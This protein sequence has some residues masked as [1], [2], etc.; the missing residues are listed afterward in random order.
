M[1]LRS[2]HIAVAVTCC[3]VVAIA[4]GL[5]LRASEPPD[6]AWLAR[7]PE[8]LIEARI[9]LPQADRHRPLAA[10]TM[11]GGGAAPG[12]LPL[13]TLARLEK[14]G[15]PRELAEA[16]L[17][18][19][20]PNL[21][22]EALRQLEGVQPSPEVE[23]DRS[24]ALL[25]K[26][27]LEEA[28]RSVD[29]ALERAPR[30]P[31]ALWNR[32]LV[33]RELQLP[34]LAAQT[35]QDVA[36]LGEPGW[37]DE[38]KQK[39]AALREAVD[40]RR[41]RWESVKAAGEALVSGKPPPGE[42]LDPH[43]PIS[44][45]YIYDAVRAA[46]SAERVLALLPLAQAFDREAGG[47]V[48]ERYVRRVAASDFR[49]RERF[50]R[51]YDAL[52]RGAFPGKERES[53]TAD[54]LRSREDDLVMGWL[55]LTHRVG[56]H[57]D[58]FEARAAA[59]GDPWFQAIAA[60]ERA[61]V[62]WARGELAQARKRL[63]AALR[64][65]RTARVEFRC[66]GLEVEL[67]TLYLDLTWMD[68]AQ[69]HASRGIAAARASADWG[70]ELQFLYNLAQGARLRNDFPLARALW[71]EVLERNRGDKQQERNAFQNLAN[72]ELN[73]LRF[74]RA[75]VEL[76]HALATGLPL[77]PLGAAVLAD[78][79]RVVPAPGDERAIEQ[80]LGATGATSRPSQVAMATHV[81]GRFAIERDPEKGRALL[82]QAIR[83]A[84][85]R[86]LSERDASARRAQAY[87]YT[88]L[89]LD[90]GRAGAFDAAMALFAE[91]LKL[92][93]PERCVLAVTADSERSL[94][95]ARGADGR[96]LG[97]YE[98]ARPTPLPANLQGF[99]PE[100]MLAALRPCERVD[101]L[102]RPPLHGRA[103][104]L[105]PDRVWLYR[106]RPSPPP[107]PVGRAVHLVVAD[108]SF[109]KSAPGLEALKPLNAW[110]PDLDPSE[111]RVV[112]TGTEATPSRVLAQMA[113]A[114]E[115]DVV[116]H[117]IVREASDASYLVLAP[118]ADGFEL[119]A[120]RIRGRRL[121]GAPLVILAACHAAHAAP[122]LYEP[123]SL[124]AAFIDA[125]ARGVIAA[126]TEI[127]DVE[128]GRFFN[129]VRARIR[130][131]ASPA[132]SVR[133]E[134]VEWTREGKGRTWLESVLVF[135]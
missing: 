92:R 90:E 62:E 72:V 107:Q 26:G 49:S 116:A 2:R 12:M 134:R 135:E 105:P 121:A 35:F 46:P 30:H 9:A 1:P 68:E 34:L 27:H 131:G 48:L 100:E 81:R 36:A 5:L 96:A 109:P 69:A 125:G 123:F 95:V 67:S 11:G 78:I 84:E 14:R 54:L 37:S 129:A 114:T 80:A 21:A 64:A 118:E 58:T 13:A 112:L 87:S 61:K 133:D 4:V 126:T 66:Q 88:S 28:L 117:G 55:V 119:T 29:R 50:V 106:T 22:D 42:G 3:T 103:G 101:V 77:T 41:R 63:D 44:R 20:D 82:R 130:A 89:L 8:R 79:A 99:V 124:P 108:V 71:R 24:V 111:A 115:V 33:L 65:C 39:A 75:R 53:L 76:D 113:S 73:A 120:T 94:L 7:A 17:V 40:A 122:V 18:R 127:P 91:E 16:Y 56:E 57:L 10:R 110:P 132:T 85:A 83:E 19:G 98:G 97:R 102:A 6:D 74:D 45:I 60:Q 15:A 104:L 47:D 43:H 32:A 25:L 59:S 70:R 128:A 52:R 93:P 23:S 31:Q 86:G 51:A 38:A